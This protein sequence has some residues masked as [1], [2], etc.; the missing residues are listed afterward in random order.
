MKYFITG[1]KGFIGSNL[2][3]ELKKNPKNKVVIYNRDLC[4]R[5]GMKNDFD[6]IFHLAA[7]SSTR[8]DAITT[9]KNNLF[10]FLNIIDFALKGKKTKLVYASS[11]AVY[12]KYKKTAYAVSKI[13]GD[14][15][16]QYFFDKMPIVGLRPFNVFG[17]NEIQKGYMASMITQWTLQIKGGMRPKAFGGERQSK[18]DHIYVKDAVKAF[19]QAIKLENGIYDVGT[20]KPRTYDDVLKAVQKT[21]GTNLKPVYIKNPYKGAYQRYTKADVGWGFKPDYTLE[22]GVKDY[23]TQ[24]FPR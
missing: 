17:P 15:I 14:E 23:L 8:D 2:A 3:E 6:V 1:A 9:L 21:L 13:T 24:H 7:I 22:Q 5:I 16:A 4:R 20:G 11:A 19:I 10:S 18:R 12:G